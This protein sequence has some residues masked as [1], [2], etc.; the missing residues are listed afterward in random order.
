MRRIIIVSLVCTLLVAVLPRFCFAD[1]RIVAIVNKEVITSKELRDFAH[2]LRLQLSR[3][4]EGSALED[5][6]KEI[7]PHLLE[8]LI[9]DRIILQEAQ[10]FGVQVN[11]D[12]VKA[13]MEDIR[14]RYASEYEFK[15]DLKKQGLVPGDIERKIREQF[16]T[17]ALIEEKVK[18]KIE[19]KPEDVTAYYRQHSS[20]YNREEERLFDTVSGN[21]DEAVRAARHDLS[22]GLSLAVVKERYAVETDEINAF[23]GRGLKPELEK[24]LFALPEGGVSDVIRA[25]DTYYIF[26]VRK[27]LPGRIWTLQESQDRIYAQL[28]QEKADV[29]M[30]TWLKELKDKAYIKILR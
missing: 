13:R 7:L 30:K 15:E 17:Y 25:G 1:D 26:R 3:E 5:K 29:I 11:E 14:K 4:Y 16:I 18:A 12:K 22:R 27:I 20:E 8:K 2:F 24:D 6:L 21:T 19:V 28:Y 9:D 23:K 10:R